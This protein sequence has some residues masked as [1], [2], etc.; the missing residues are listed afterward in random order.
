MFISL[1]KL[2]SEQKVN[3]MLSKKRPNGNRLQQIMVFFNTNKATLS[4]SLTKSFACHYFIFLLLKFFTQK[5]LK[6]LLFHFPQGKSFDEA[7]IRRFRKYNFFFVS[8][9]SFSRSQSQVKCSFE[10]YSGKYFVQMLDLA[11]GWIPVV[12]D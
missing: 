3:F 1:K 2:F 6:I 8:V 10:F 12:V 9:K 4:I 7:L 5:V 11:I